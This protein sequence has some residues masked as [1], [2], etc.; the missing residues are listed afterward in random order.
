MKNYN[1]ATQVRLNWI[2]CI[3]CLSGLGFCVYV[4]IEQWRK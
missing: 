1:V 2:Y 3:V 4:L